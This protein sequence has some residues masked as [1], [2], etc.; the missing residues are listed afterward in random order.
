MKL[1]LLPLVFLILG[2]ESTPKIKTVEELKKE[3]YIFEGKSIRCNEYN[4]AYYRNISDR[5]TSYI[6][7]YKSPTEVAT[8]EEIKEKRLTK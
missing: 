2:C 7:V 5:H 4:M 8:C 6:P 1:I 3:Q